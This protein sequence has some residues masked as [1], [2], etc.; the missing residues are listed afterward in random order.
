M[1]SLKAALFLALVVSAAGVIIRGPSVTYD[2]YIRA[3]SSSTAPIINYATTNYNDLRSG[4]WDGPLTISTTTGAISGTS[5]DTSAVLIMFDL[6][7]LVGATLVPTN[8][9]WLYYFMS[10][11]GGN[12]SLHELTVPWNHVCTRHPRRCALPS[13]P[14]G[15]L[16]EAPSR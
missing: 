13:Q 3:G 10:D 6:N 12:P 16:A 8:P 7:S 15:T 5:S 4:W 9:V 11:A 2:T 1:T 14:R